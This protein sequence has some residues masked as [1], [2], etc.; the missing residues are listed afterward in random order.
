MRR[1]VQHL[2][3]PPMAVALL[4]LFVALGSSA[5]AIGAAKAPKNSVVAKSIK[6]GAVTRA[7]IANDAVN[8][9]KVAPGSLSAADI[10]VASLGIPQAT[11]YV[12]RTET[13]EGV[14]LPIGSGQ[15][16]SVKCQPGEL[17]VGGGARAS[18]SQLAL[19]ESS[20]SIEPKL[21]GWRALLVNHGTSPSVNSQIQ[22]FA[23]CAS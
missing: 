19:S 20:P 15:E 5:Y 13:K 16:V 2:P 9:A 1:L 21:Q 7:K 22:A 3:S 23:I 4:A 11:K 10:D 12:L 14:S 6:K 8:G 17:V 18:A